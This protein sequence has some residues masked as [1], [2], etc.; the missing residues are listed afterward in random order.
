MFVVHNFAVNMSSQSRAKLKGHKINYKR[1]YSQPHVVNNQPGS[2]DV[3]GHYR[4]GLGEETASPLSTGVAT[5]S[6]VILQFQAL[7]TEKQRYH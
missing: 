3:K 6:I 1:D 2:H 7:D 4:M 5:M